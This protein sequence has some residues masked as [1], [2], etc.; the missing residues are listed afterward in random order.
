MNKRK[1]I[2][3]LEKIIPKPGGGT[4]SDKTYP[5]VGVVLENFSSPLV[6]D[7]NHDGVTSLD[8][9]ATPAYFDMEK[10]GI[11]EKTGWIQS[12]DALL[13]FDKNRDGIINDGT[14][15]FGNNT[16]LSNGTKASN[17][18]EALKEYDENKDGV[19]D[20]KDNIY[21]ALRLWQD[22]NSNGVTDAG[23]L[24]TLKELGVASINLDYLN[25]SDYEEQNTL[26]QISSFTTTEGETKIINDVWFKTNDMDTIKESITLSDSVNV[27]PDYHGAGRAEN[28]STAINT[29]T[30]LES[31]LLRWNR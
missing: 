6:L 8:L 10:D 13:A 22:S 17:G 26:N 2:K 5:R 19:I 14:E 11:R 30:K 24:H 31:K 20:S 12:T 4:M 28:L 27:L 23:E 1:I 29:N 21:N 7:L 25:T 3:T 9:Y 18:F 16:L 15:L